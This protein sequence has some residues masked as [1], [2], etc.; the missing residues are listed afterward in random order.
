MRRHPRSVRAL[1][2]GLAFAHALSLPNPAFALRG[3]GLEENAAKEEVTHTLQSHAARVEEPTRQ[4][5][6]NVLMEQARSL[7]PQ[8]WE[9][10]NALFGE[11]LRLDSHNVRVV[12]AKTQLLLA[13]DRPA[14]A[15]SL[16]EGYQRRRPHDPFLTN[17]YARAL[18]RLRRAPEALPALQEALTHQP[19]NPYLGGTAAKILNQLSRYE[20]A[21]IVTEAPFQRYPNDVYLLEHRANA[22]N[23]LKRPNEAL[24]LAERA[25]RLRPNYHMART[26]ARAF[27]GLRRYDEALHVIEAGLPWATSSARGLLELKARVLIEQGHVEEAIGVIEQILAGPLP[28]DHISTYRL[29][30]L[31][32][33]QLGQPERAR[34]AVQPLIEHPPQTPNAQRPFALV[35]H[36][37]GEDRLALKVLERYLEQVP[38]DSRARALQ[39]KIQRALPHEIARPLA[40]EASPTT[41]LEE[42]ERERLETDDKDAAAGLEEIPSETRQLI[43]RLQ[44]GHRAGVQVLDQRQRRFSSPFGRFGRDPGL[45]SSM[46][47]M[48]EMARQ[49][50]PRFHTA[51]STGL[52]AYPNM[53]AWLKFLGE[54]NT[55]VFIPA[56]EV[57]PQ[58]FLDQ[59]RWRLARWRIQP[60][61]WKRGVYLDSLPVAEADVYAID[62]PAEYPDAF[63]YGS[64]AF[65]APAK[66]RTSSDGEFQRLMETQPASNPIIAA[67]QTQLRASNLDNAE[68]F[69]VMVREDARFEERRHAEDFAYAQARLRLRPFKFHGIPDLQPGAE[70]VVRTAEQIV[71]D[72]RGPLGRLL[73]QD[74]F[75]GGHRFHEQVELTNPIVEVAGQLGGVIEAMTTYRRRGQDD[76]A[77]LVFLRHYAHWRQS[78][79]PDLQQ[80]LAVLTHPHIQAQIQIPETLLDLARL[81]PIY[82]IVLDELMSAAGI[83]AASHTDQD[84]QLL[85]YCQ[86]AGRDTTPASRVLELLQRVYQQNFVTDEERARQL[87]MFTG[88][89]ERVAAVDMLAAR[90]QERVTS[91]VQQWRTGAAVANLERVGIIVDGAMSGALTLTTG[92]EELGVPVVVVQPDEAARE[93]AQRFVQ[94][95]IPI[96][97]TPE[98]AR[99]VLAERGVTPVILPATASLEDALQQLQRLGVWPLGRDLRPLLA[100]GLEE[101]RLLHAAAQYST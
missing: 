63:A 99:A 6:V 91:V 100:A 9:Q 78:S 45:S 98:A 65:L 66:L 44:A 47:E 36:Y 71:G 95:A 70:S 12:T 50:N 34:Q 5:R 56:G 85:A 7:P 69:G 94:G 38:G 55:Q 4:E 41:G 14:E 59:G 29:A 19:A 86:E 48:L 83:Q 76:R 92:L 79:G 73:F 84:T 40:N 58:Y 75:S 11:A 22:L 39:G 53:S 62:V 89:E 68:A 23:A 1:A 46:A 33:H 101:A 64:Y 24:P 67:L 35:L 72:S 96:V 20:D 97:A 88:L 27:S 30:V 57:A 10:A 90:F 37:V 18:D 28:E 3:A 8:E 61:T 17:L 54:L 26:L 60:E 49:A 52:V 87:R 74:I 13:H 81:A 93:V 82:S 77:W 42:F 25:Y 31:A 21:L 2:F 15:L 16:V 43:E 32:Y 80:R 51:M